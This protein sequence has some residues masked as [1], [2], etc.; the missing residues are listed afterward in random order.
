MK[1][2]LVY[3]LASGYW[4]LYN[5]YRDLEGAENIVSKLTDLQNDE[6]RIECWEVK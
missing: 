5:I 4:D 6:K 2:Y 3:I 1:V